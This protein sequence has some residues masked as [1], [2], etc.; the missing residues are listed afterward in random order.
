MTNFVFAG[1][2]GGR[3]RIARESRADG[4]PAPAAGLPA[5]RTFP[6]DGRSTYAAR[7]RGTG[8]EELPP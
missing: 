5:L 4:S 1:W 8:D 3:P 2:L 7:G 6:G